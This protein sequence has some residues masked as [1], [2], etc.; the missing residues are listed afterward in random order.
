MCVYIYICH[1]VHVLVVQL[2]HFTIQKVL[3][4]GDLSLHFLLGCLQLV[5]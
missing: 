2:A 5:L 4:S 3:D 1:L